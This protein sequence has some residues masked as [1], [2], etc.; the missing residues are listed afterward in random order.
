MDFVKWFKSKQKPKTKIKPRKPKQLS[1]KQ[2]KRLQ[3]KIELQE[4]NYNTI[5]NL[6]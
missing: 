6:M 1:K 2:R 3:Q 4:N 5:L